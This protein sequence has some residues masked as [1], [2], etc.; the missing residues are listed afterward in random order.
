MSYYVR[1]LTPAEKTTPFSE[2]LKLGNSYKLVSGTDTFW[3]KIE[4]YQPEGSLIAIL[5]RHP[6]SDGGPFEN[7]MV[8]LKSTIENSYP[9]NAREWLR[10]YLSMVKTIYSFQ[11][12]ADNIKKGGWP[13]LGKIQNLL[14]DNLTGIIQA[15]NEGFYNENGDYILW[16]MYAG[17]RGT[18]PAATMDENGVW[19]PF[20]LKLEDS[21]AIEQFKQGIPTK[22]G[23]L[24]KLLGKK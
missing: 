16:Q 21:Q 5:E 15:D 4:I 7:E 3:D 20:H 18:I 22:K 9:A 12:L 11:L 2:I 19:V 8:K 13:V 10:K 24:S 6:M 14:K 23:F 17:A 1:L